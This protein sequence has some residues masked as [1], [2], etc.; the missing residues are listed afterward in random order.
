MDKLPPLPARLKPPFTADEF[1]REDR[2]VQIHLR[3]NAKLTALADCYA[4]KS[5]EL[6]TFRDI[7]ALLAGPDQLAIRR[8]IDRFI[9]EVK[10]GAFPVPRAGL[11]RDRR[12]KALVDLYS[13]DLI[14]S[15]DAGQYPLR[16]SV[17]TAHSVP[18]EMRARRS[19]W[20]QWIRAHP[21]WSVPPSLSCGVVIDHEPTPSEQPVSP[22]ST[23]GEQSVSLELAAPAA[24]QASSKRRRRGN[25]AYNDDTIMARAAE[26]YSTLEKPNRKKAAMRAVEEW[27]SNN[28]QAAIPASS[29]TAWVDRI[30][31]KVWPSSDTDPN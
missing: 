24:P 25:T 26:F 10:I 17:F 28:P 5:D 18:L 15:F 16:P 9:A 29:V 21:G 11:Y 14:P 23:P 13:L 12:V 8:L 3:R 27:K 22:K 30:C 19:V 6:I 31:H 2:R 7:V 4:A 20:V 1:D